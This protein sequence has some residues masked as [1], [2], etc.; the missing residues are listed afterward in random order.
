MGPNALQPCLDPLGGPRVVST[1]VV[2]RTTVLIICSV[3][4]MTLH[5]TA[6]YHQVDPKGSCSYD[7]EVF[8]PHFSADGKSS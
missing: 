4:L 3:V 8:T 6:Q 5:R 7:A 1:K 2:I